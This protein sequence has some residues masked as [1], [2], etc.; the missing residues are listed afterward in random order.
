M[1]WLLKLKS[2]LGR[3]RLFALALALSCLS[4]CSSAYTTFST[5]WFRG[6]VRDASRSSRTLDSPS[7]PTQTSDALSQID[8][9]MGITFL[10]DWTLLERRY[11]HLSPLQLDLFGVRILWPRTTLSEFNLCS[12]LR[13]FLAAHRTRARRR[14]RLKST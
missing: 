13:Q 7:I 11:F 14:R 2:S 4:R 12:E 6:K 9:L 1:K 10:R 5:M 8:S 3:A